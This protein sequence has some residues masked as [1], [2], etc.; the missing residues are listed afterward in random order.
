[1]DV[2]TADGSLK[3][4]E[5]GGQRLPDS[6]ALTS[7]AVRRTLFSAAVHILSLAVRTSVGRTN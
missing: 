3:S 7:P 1:M 5:F 4:E 6:P 2:L